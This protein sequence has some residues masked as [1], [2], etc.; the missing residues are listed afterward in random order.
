MKV[1]IGVKGTERETFFRLVAELVPWDAAGTIVLAHVIDATGHA[2]IAHGRER[3]LARRPL[4]EE[5]DR[6]IV[7]AEEERAAAI[8]RSGHSALAAAGLP[9]DRLRAV[10]LRGRPNERLRDLAERE[11][12]DLI[13][14][15]ARD[16]RPGPH[17]L[18]KTARFLVDHA[19]HAALLVRSLA[20][21]RIP[22]Q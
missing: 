15:G 5:R 22:K 9:A 18:G 4:R 20:S 13:V 12:I 8:L 6:E 14:V 11:E 1:L 19:P 16:E 10:T 7:A 21:S 3:Y 2:G 17:S